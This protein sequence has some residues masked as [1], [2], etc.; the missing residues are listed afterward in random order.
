VIFVIIVINTESTY[1][2]CVHDLWSNKGRIFYCKGNLTIEHNVQI[3]AR[4]I[5]SILDKYSTTKG[6]IPC[7]GDPKRKLRT[8]QA[9]GD[10]IRN[11]EPSNQQWITTG[12]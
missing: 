9:K 11:R 10:F 12:R 8:P 1:D 3:L 2:G 7:K 4:G 6:C 5:Q